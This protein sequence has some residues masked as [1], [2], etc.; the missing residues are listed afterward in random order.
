MFM[1]KNSPSIFSI[2]GLYRILILICLTIVSVLGQEANNNVDSKRI[3][4]LATKII[5]AKSLEERVKLADSNRELITN[6]FIKE[7]GEKINTI[8]KKAEY[9]KAEEIITW[10]MTIDNSLA[11]AIGKCLKGN[12][13]RFKGEYEKAAR[14]YESSLNIGE[15]INNKEVVAKVLEGI[16]LIYFDQGKS[17]ALEYHLKSLKIREEIGDKRGIAASLINIG[18]IHSRQGNYTQALDYYLK[19]LKIF[20]EIGNKYGVTTS[21]SNIGRVHYSQG[22]YTQALEYHLKGLQIREEIG[23]KRG[24]A[25]SSTS[26]G[27]VHNSQGNY[28]QALEYHLKSLKIFEEIGDKSGVA[29]SLI[30][31]GNVHSSQGNYTQA[32]DYYLK[33]LKIN[34]KIGDKRGIASSLNNIGVVY[35]RQ[36]NY[37]QALE[38][39]LKSL[40]IKEEIG[41][42]SGVAASL[43]N[44]GML[45]NDQGSDTQAL[46]YH[47]KSLKLREETGNMEGVVES[48]NNI[49]KIH[50]KQGDFRKS[51][52][53]SL[54]VTSIASESNMLDILWQALSTQAKAYM[55]LNQL[56][57]A[58][59]TLLQ[60]IA[61]V[62]KLRALSVGSEQTQQSFFQDKTD[63]YYSMV[64]LLIKKHVIHQS[65]SYAERAKGRV[66]LDVLHS[67]RANL[68]KHMSTEEV[69]KDQKL[70]S[71]MFS[72]NAQLSHVSQKDNP[73]KTLIA[74]L[75]T[76]LEKAR[77]EYEAFQTSLYVAH[78]ELKIQRGEIPPLKI[79]D[80]ANLLDKKTA[81]LEYAVTEDATYLFVLT[82]SK[83]NRPNLQ[84]YTINIKSKDLDKKIADFHQ[85]VSSR[86]LAVRRPAQELYSL[87]LKPAMKQ[88]QGIDRL[89]I[90]PDG[91]LWNLPFQA[92]DDGDKWMID[93]YS[94]YYAPS[95]S[96][97]HEIR[98]NR[99]K[100][101][102]VA[103]PELLA[104]GNP[105]LQG[106]TIEKVRSWY[107]SGA[108][109]AL[110][111]AEEEVKMLGSLYGKD[112]SK[113]LVGDQAREE[114]VKGEASKYRIVHFATHGI[115]D[116]KSPLY[117][118]LML[119]S[120]DGT[121]EDGM[122]EA[123]EI[124][125]MDLQ[126]DMAVLAA[127][128]T[129]RG[130]VSAGEGMIGMSWAM[131]VAGVPTTVV[132]QWKVDSEATSK[133]MVEFHKHLLAKKSKSEAMRAAAIKIKDE[134][135]IHPYYWAGFVVIGDGR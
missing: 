85:I 108:L 19:S 6:E 79:D 111:H 73:D 127:C 13:Y 120:E 91:S 20:E 31:I 3:E 45:H 70:S 40:K 77:L 105:K 124:M 11:L 131:F 57:A 5:E 46:E 27:N 12:V 25:A 133:L 128:E 81:I 53:Y 23:D 110:P 118:R 42:K 132:S 51:L 9:G 117:S 68:H 52:D 126:A 44:I 71:A 59:Q 122:L 130:R 58:H 29:A 93:R 106:S 65:L 26:I 47:L 32:L 62:E 7:V 18:N 1:T 97:L 17:Q 35:R 50:L 98:K 103:N 60:S 88:L 86:N 125:R 96:V 84:A 48:M 89:C 76:K 113:V 72:L 41:D 92:L 90:V 34:E 114:I 39:H 100:R 74:E 82:K 104:L 56:D 37:T 115:L 10:L 134:F 63:P 49:S 38:Y 36:G 116:D 109:E 129:A 67:G 83:E 64:S 121:K 66:I 43:N 55:A 107:R 95:L 87:L 135:N 78:P 112:K 54:K 14:E 123:W 28:T 99:K 4:E 94:I 119:A 15:Q 21:L 101:Q 22:N 102:D 8:I 30:N 16:G 61:T 80:A 33:G 75:K 24:V 2:K 69:D